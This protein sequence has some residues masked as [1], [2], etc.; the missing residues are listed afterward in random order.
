MR[1]KEKLKIL[2]CKDYNAEKKTLLSIMGDVKKKAE[3]K[4]LNF[5]KL[6]KSFLQRQ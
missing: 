1:D 4:N 2:S 3:L 6:K 5:I